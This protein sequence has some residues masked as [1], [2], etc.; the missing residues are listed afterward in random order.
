MQGINKKGHVGSWAVGMPQGRVVGGMS[1][2]AHKK[3]S[4]QSS[5]TKSKPEQNNE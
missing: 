5:T 2:N 1:R 3:S 4:R